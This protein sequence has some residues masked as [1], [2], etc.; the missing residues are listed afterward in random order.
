MAE[1]HAN[2]ALHPSQ[3]NE[4]C[5]LSEKKKKKTHFETTI[6]SIFLLMI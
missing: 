2:M 4:P 5:I 3:E 6:E 1:L